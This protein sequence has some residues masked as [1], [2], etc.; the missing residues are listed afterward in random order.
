MAAKRVTLSWQ[1]LWGKDGLFFLLQAHPFLFVSYYKR[2]KLAQ[3]VKKRHNYSGSFPV[4][5]EGKN[6]A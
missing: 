4:G 1:L 5:E 3:C 2:E 6:Y